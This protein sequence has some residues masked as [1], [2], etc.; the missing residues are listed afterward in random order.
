MNQA[1][2]NKIPLDS[3]LTVLGKFVTCICVQYQLIL[4]SL[5]I[6][7]FKCDHN[8]GTL[9]VIHLKNCVYK[10]NGAKIAIILKLL[11][12]VLKDCITV[13]IFSR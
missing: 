12:D 5:R 2:R 1:T 4:I 3:N 7:N 8:H 9:F 13:E 10:M 6:S 11:T